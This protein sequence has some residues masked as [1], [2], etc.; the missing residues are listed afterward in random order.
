MGFF[1]TLLGR[2]AGNRAPATPSAIATEPPSF[3]AYLEAAVRAS[4]DFT[5]EGKELIAEHLRR[6]KE[7]ER[8]DLPPKANRAAHRAEDDALDAEAARIL[9]PGVKAGS[10]VTTLMGVLFVEAATTRS[11]D[12]TIQSCRDLGLTHVTLMIPQTGEECAWCV[13]NDGAKFPVKDD[14]NAL[15][16][17]NCTCTPSPKCFFNAVVEGFDA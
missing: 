10:R 16:R 12:K 14:I 4:A 2:S 11:R 6:R 5:A 8:A 13:A 17:K 9:S 3:D 1:K 15:L 7:R